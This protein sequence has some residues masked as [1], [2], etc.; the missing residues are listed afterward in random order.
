MAVLTGLIIKEM[1]KKHGMTAAELAERIS[2]DPTTV[3]RYESGEIRVDPDTMYL[4][5]SALGDPKKWQDMMREE[6]PGSYGRVHPAPLNYDLPGSVLSLYA[7]VDKLDKNRSRV[8]RDTADGKIDD[9]KLGARL[10]LLS[11]QLISAA[12]S[13]KALLPEEGSENGGKAF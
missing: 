3:Y 8:F 13:I 7:L 4:I 11:E 1:R 10:M 2:C 9:D 12:Q 6:Y 5:C